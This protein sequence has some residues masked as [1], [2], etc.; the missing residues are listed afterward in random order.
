MYVGNVPAKMH[1]KNET[2]KYYGYGNPTTSI[3]RG[4]FQEHLKKLTHKTGPRRPYGAYR[5]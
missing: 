3:N 4:P 1:G 5:N 2:T